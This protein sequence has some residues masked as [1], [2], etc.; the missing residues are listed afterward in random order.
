MRVVVDTNVIVSG[1]L[2]GGVPRLILK[3]A[4][5]RDVTLCFTESTIAELRRTLT[6]P[7]FERQRQLL[8]PNLE[9]AIDMLVAFSVRVAEPIGIPL[10]IKSDPS[11][12][13]FLACAVAAQAKCIISGD[14][15]L[16][17]VK[18]FGGIPI[19]TPRQFLKRYLR[20]QR[21]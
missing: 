14:K 18:D 5:N 21:L 9:I 17:D 16:L 15:H 8:A 6:Y 11:D 19:V 10:T 20:G 3:F 2:F 1:L 7:K 13:M 12:D 4:R